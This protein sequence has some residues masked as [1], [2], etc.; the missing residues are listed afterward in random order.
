MGGGA[1]E[2]SAQELF[3]PNSCPSLHCFAAKTPLAGLR[4]KQGQ[5]W[6]LLGREAP[7]KQ[8]A[9]MPISVRGTLLSIQH[10]TNIPQAALG[11]LV[12]ERARMPRLLR[13]AHFSCSRA[14]SFPS[15][16]AL[17]SAAS[18][19]ASCTSGR[20]GICTGLSCVLG[21]LAEEMHKAAILHALG[22]IKKGSLPPPALIS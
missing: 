4:A 9:G 6:S 11:E 17:G 18:L 21:D 12:T 14:S 2:K 15:L 16:G 7:K 13:H 10:R 3:Q 22:L 8:S 1:L 5:A 19:A 20:A